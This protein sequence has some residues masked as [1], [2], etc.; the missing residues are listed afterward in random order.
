MEI[1]QDLFAS[2]VEVGLEG[3]G[4]VGQMI[5][6]VDVLQVASRVSR[7]PNS[8]QVLRFIEVHRL[9]DIFLQDKSGGDAGNTGSNDSDAQGFCMGHLLNSP[10][11]RFRNATSEDG[12]KKE[13]NETVN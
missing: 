11:A 12:M 2:R 10:F 1:A 4:K 5:L 6:G 8:T 9:T 13:R 3:P 7:G